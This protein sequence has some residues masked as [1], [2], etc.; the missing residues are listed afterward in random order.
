MSDLLSYD[1]QE[2]DGRRVVLQTVDL[3]R[4]YQQYDEVDRKSVV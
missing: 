1:P 2:I 4:Q 3:I